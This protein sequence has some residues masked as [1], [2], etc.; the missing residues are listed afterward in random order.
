MVD[1]DG[2][3]GCVA[4]ILANRPQGSCPHCPLS[5]AQVGQRTLPRLLRHFPER[6]RHTLPPISAV[7]A[8]AAILLGGLWTSSTWGQQPDAAVVHINRGLAWHKLDKLDWAIDEYRTT[9]RFR[10]DFAEAHYNL[11]NA[12]L[13][14]GKLEEGIAEFHK[15]SDNAQPGFELAQL[16]EQALTGAGR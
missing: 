4:L 3:P 13:G 14:Q 15:A 10:P 16:I 9:I 6:T 1:H 7:V 5:D 2:S 11:G 8:V 12:L